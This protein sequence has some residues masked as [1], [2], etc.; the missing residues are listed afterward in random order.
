MIKRIF[1]LFTVL[2]LNILVVVA[3]SIGQDRQK[4]ERIISFD[5]NIHIYRNAAMSVVETISVYSA[6]KEIKRGI[7]RDFPTKY[8]DR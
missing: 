1:F 3:V 5:S 8:K 4:S 2:F 7:Y 6:G